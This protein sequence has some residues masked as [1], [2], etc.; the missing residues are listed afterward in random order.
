MLGSGRDAA[1][2]AVESQKERKGGGGESRE[3]WQELWRQQL[4]LNHGRRQAAA[5]V[6]DYEQ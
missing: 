4:R 2:A 6:S 5:G 3:R 1:G